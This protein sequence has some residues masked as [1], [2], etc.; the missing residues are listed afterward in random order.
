[1]NAEQRRE[2][3]REYLV[4]EGF[5]ASRDD[6]GDIHFKFEGKNYYVIVDDTDEEF[7]RLIYPNFWSIEDEDER[8]RAYVAAHDAS[9]R[10]K[11]AKVYVR[12]DDTWA[13]VEMFCAP[14]EVFRAVFPRSL[15]ALQSAVQTFVEIM[16]DG[17][18]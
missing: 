2:L 15:S 12:K 8:A 7:F 16:R 9:A 18:S 1:L 17:R 10:T 6:D 11:V 3:Y 14:P 13:A 5:T 4:G